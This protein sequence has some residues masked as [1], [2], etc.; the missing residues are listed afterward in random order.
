M[1][2]FNY[3][4]N[5][6][7][8]D[9]H[10]KELLSGSCIALFL[11]IMGLVLSYFFIAFVS[12]IYGA[13]G[14]GVFAL[15][16]TFL[17]I[18]TTLSKFGTEMAFLRFSA[19]Y[20]VKN[21]WN[22]IKNIAKKISIIVSI[23][24]IFIS[25][26]AYNY[27]NF[28]ASI[29]LKKTYMILPL[30]I[31]SFGIFPFSFFVLFSEGLRGLKKIKEYMILRFVGLNFLSIVLLF[32][33]I[34]ISSRNSFSF[35]FNSKYSI[36]TLTYILSGVIFSIITYY[37]WVKEFKLFSEDENDYEE[38]ITFLSLLSVS[39]PI[40]FSNSLFLIVGWADTIMLGVFKT[41][42]EVGYYNVASK[43]AKVIV[44][45]LMAINAIAAPKFAEFWEKKDIEGLVKMAKQATKLIFWTTLPFFIFLMVFPGIVLS[46]FGKDFIASSTC[47]IILLIG[48][49]FNAISGSVG[50]VLLMTGHQVFHQKIIFVGALINIVLNYLL[51]P[52]FGI[53]GA[54]FASA[55]SMIFWNLSFG[56][57]VKK[58]TGS[59]IFYPKI[60][61]D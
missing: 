56:F 49:F 11:R 25:L 43:I 33:F 51:I 40:L 53:N 48:F 46:F 10:L 6:M 36:P 31:V 9:P 1:N 3:F 44:I 18:F 4:K 17:N 12:H 32:I 37:L 16:F 30:K 26:I 27:S 35:I 39:V 57:K 20:H 42:T 22:A 52:K 34:I 45:I 19:E 29:V 24:S 61:G 41:A 21:D 7:Q 28:L 23:S 15:A 14:V 5:K 13:D 50:L 60:L 38:N 59:W 8:N 58:I 55:I 54:A 47:L 2:L